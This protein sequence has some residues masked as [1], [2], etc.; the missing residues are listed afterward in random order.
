MQDTSAIKSSNL[1]PGWKVDWQKQKATRT[2]IIKNPLT[3]R[4]TNII[5]K[6]SG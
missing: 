2:P 5:L 4:I 6:F 3:L 1:S